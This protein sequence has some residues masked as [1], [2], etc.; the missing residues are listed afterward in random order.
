M[1][2]NRRWGTAMRD[3]FHTEPNVQR[4]YR[5]CRA[6]RTASSLLVCIVFRPRPFAEFVELNK[7]WFDDVQRHYVGKLYKLMEKLY[8]EKLYEERGMDDIK[9]VLVQHL[10]VITYYNYLIINKIPPS[11]SSNPSHCQ[12]RDNNKK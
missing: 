2:K 5:P 10:I 12:N 9:N 1:D 6:P 4:K 7:G 8:E 3:D 11:R